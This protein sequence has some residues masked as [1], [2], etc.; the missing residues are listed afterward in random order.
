MPAWLIWLLAAG[1]L[2]IAEAVSLDLVLIMLAVGGAMLGN[3]IGHLSRAAWLAGPWRFGVHT[4]GSVVLAM[5]MFMVLIGL[6]YL[7]V[8]AWWIRRALLSPPPALDEVLLPRMPNDTWLP[9][10]ED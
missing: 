5:S 4:I 1:V 8:N 7:V 10:R 3:V 2:A 6:A 9:D